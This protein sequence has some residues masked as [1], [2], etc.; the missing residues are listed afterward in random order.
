MAKFKAFI[1]SVMCGIS[2]ITIMPSTNY[3]ECVPQN[4]NVITKAAWKRTG[5]SLKKSI[6]RVGKCIEQSKACKTK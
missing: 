5:E 4:A 6:D 2:A 3:A 1:A